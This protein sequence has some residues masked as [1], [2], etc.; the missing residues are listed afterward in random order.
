LFGI[1]KIQVFHPIGMV[2]LPSSLP[3]WVGITYAILLSK[4][5]HIFGSLFPAEKWCINFHKNVFVH[6]LGNLPKTHLVTL[7]ETEGRI[8]N[9]DWS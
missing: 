2:F 8:T 3:E 4:E 6:I 5:D 1:F 7:T 9:G